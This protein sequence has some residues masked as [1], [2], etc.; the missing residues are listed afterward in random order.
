MSGNQPILLAG[1]EGGA[2]HSVLILFDQTMKQLAKVEGP[3]TNFF[4]IGIDETGRVIEKMVREALQKSGL[5]ETT[6]LTGIG[7]SLS[8]GES[9]ETNQRI[10]DTLCK[11][12]PNLSKHY[13]VVSDTVGPIVTASPKGGLVLI[14]GTGSNSLFMNPDG[15]IVR[16]GGWGHLIGD[17]GSASWVALRGVKIYFNHVDNKVKAPHDITELERA[18]MEYFQISDRFEMLG[19]LYEK[20][21]KSFFAG[22]CKRISQG[23]QKGDKLCA[24]LLEEAGREMASHLVAML[25]KISEE[26]LEYPGG[27][28]VVCIGSVWKSWNFMEPGFMR[29]LR[30]HGRDKLKEIQLLTCTAP[31]PIGACYLVADKANVK[32]PKDYA[33]NTNRFFQSKI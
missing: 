20:W 9:E 14:A 22:L 33:H 15:S 30:T 11:N 4:Q 7:M 23:A 28:P 21:N 18:I 13:V 3:S 29:E 10:I 19:P 6:T 32:V 25:P 27:L 17:E 12:F 8:G 31:V 26:S 1:V 16:C 2:T 5:S 24:Y